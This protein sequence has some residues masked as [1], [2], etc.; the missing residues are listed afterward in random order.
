MAWGG[1]NNGQIPASAMRELR[2][3]PGDRMRAD[4]ADYFDA[5]A[6]AF[7]ERFGKGLVVLEAYRTLVTQTNLFEARYTPVPWPTTLRWNSKYWVR[8]AGQSAAAIPGLSNHGWGLAVDLASGVNNFNSN[9][10]KWMLE[11]APKFG[12]GNKQGRADGEPWHWVFGEYAPTFKLSLAGNGAVIPIDNSTT[13]TPSV[14]EDDLMATAEQ[15]QQLITELLN[16]PA[17]DGGPSVSTVLKTLNRLPEQLTIPII[18]D[19]RDGKLYLASTETGVQRI[20]DYV[21]PD[22][23][24]K[25]VVDAVN[26]AFGEYHTPASAWEFDVL[27]AIINRIAEAYQ[28]KLVAQLAAK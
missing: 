18:Q 20:A 5:L 24:N 11:N 7:R 27:V 26:G 3:E 19:P 10:Y 28:A 2:A 14:Q 15:R 1:Y 6:T 9:E 22:M 16:N 21:S 12:F 8:K 4:A 17:F 13:T 25:T 23:D